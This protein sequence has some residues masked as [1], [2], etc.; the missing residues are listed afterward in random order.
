MLKRTPLYEEHLK[1]GA[2]ASSMCPTWEK[3]WSKGKMPEI[4]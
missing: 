2:R 1:L 4:F 3:S